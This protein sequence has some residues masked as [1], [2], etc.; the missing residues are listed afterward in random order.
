MT[1]LGMFGVLLA[2]VLFA[3]S[4][5]SQGTEHGANAAELAR[6]IRLGQ[7]TSED[8]TR[9]L[10]RRISQLDRSGPRIQSV[11]SLNPNALDAAIAMD[12][13][14][15]T[16]QFRGPLHGV[17]ILLKDN[18]ESKELPTTAG[19]LAL[20]NNTTGRDA[21]I[22]AR[23]R[24]AG[25]I[26]LGKTN[27]SEWANY[28]SFDSISGWSGVGG[29][30]RNPYDLRR[31][32]CGSSSGSAA[33]VAAAFV[34]VAIGTETNGSITCPAAV[35]GLVG[36]KPTVG[37]VSRRHIVP[38]SP[39][40]DSAGP[41]TQTV[42]DAAMLLSALAGSDPQDPATRDAD[43]HVENYVGAL[44]EGIT[45]MRIGVFRWAQGDNESVTTVF[46]RALERLEQAGAVLVDVEDFSP[47][48]ILWQQGDRILQVEF[49]AGLNN[50]LATTP[51]DID[52]RS[53][54]DLIEFNRIN[55]QRELALFDQSILIKTAA[56]DD[57]DDPAFNKVVSE[58]VHAARDRGLDL[59]LAEHDVRLLVMPTT[60]PAAPVDL[61]GTSEPVGGPLGAGWLAATAGY[62]ILTVPMG[63]HR[64]LPLGMSFMGTAWDDAALLRAGHALERA[65]ALRQE[66][67]FLDGDMARPGLAD[68]LVPI[69]EGTPE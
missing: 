26:I 33:A 12:R 19:S 55:A 61:L 51:A 30:T 35:M 62:P 16:G 3:S 31:S 44:S 4:A 50:Y 8:A 21:P 47:E 40:Q 13:E 63:D 37:L 64:G 42:E 15:Q 2:A 53:I 10:L 20:I 25:M 56:A 46:D 57:A 28:R 18:I 65:L 23:L 17:P 58:F 34:P 59:L 7:T 60:K 69:D 67:A 22:V 36:L 14:A 41:I 29:L 45:G 66:P 6:Q 68:V 32:A 43:S 39:R 11:I 38:L 5:Q 49:K 54:N 9:A 27:L 48:P 24:E 1:R 52:V